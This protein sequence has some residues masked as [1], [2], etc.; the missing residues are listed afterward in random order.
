[1]IVKA[2]LLGELDNVSDFTYYSDYPIGGSVG[3]VSASPDGTGKSFALDGYWG[4][5]S[6]PCVLPENHNGKTCY[7]RVYLYI[8]ASIVGNSG[9]LFTVMA[10]PT[11]GEQVRLYLNSSRQLAAYRGGTLLG[12][13]AS[14]LATDVWHE[15]QSEV[16]VHNSSGKFNIYLNN[17][18]ATPEIPYTGNTQNQANA[19]VKSFFFGTS[20][21]GALWGAYF[22]DPL[23]FN[24]DG[25][26]NDSLIPA[27]AKIVKLPLNGDGA[28]QWNRNTGANNYGNLNEAFGA[29]DGDTAYLY[30]S[31]VGDK[32][33]SDVTDP[34]FAGVPLGF[35]VISRISK[36]QSG[37]R[38]V[39]TGLK[40]G[41][42]EIKTERYLPIGY[43]TYVDIIQTSDGIS[44]PLTMSDVTNTQALAEISV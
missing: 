10:N 38:A 8:P 9:T 25:P 41:A 7:F 5:G 19:D 35:Q 39:K 4:N 33:L 20:T 22:N 28:A 15:I 18:M 1:M 26:V 11:S 12:T 27:G 40:I 36:I 13:G 14:V 29:P 16:L 32:N 44:T 6:V 24:S 34:A 3:L 31:S 42:N 37:S 2:W 21:A 30:G 17:S 43:K 23:L